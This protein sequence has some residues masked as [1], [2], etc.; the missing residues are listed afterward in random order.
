MLLDSFRRYVQPHSGFLHT[1]A[2]G[3]VLENVPL[4][5]RQSVAVFLGLQAKVVTDKNLDGPGTKDP[6]AR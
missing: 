6:L 4:S 5:R 3:T 2:L 1:L